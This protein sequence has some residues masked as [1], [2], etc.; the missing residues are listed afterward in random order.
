MAV[1]ILINNG[2][3]LNASFQGLQMPP[4]A[5]S[6]G[7]M[8]DVVTL[9]NESWLGAAAP[10]LHLPALAAVADRFDSAD[11]LRFPNIISPE[12]SVNRR[13]GIDYY[14]EILEQIV[15]VSTVLKEKQ[16][17]R[18][19]NLGCDCGTDFA[20]I[21]YLL[22]R[23]REN[24][25][26]FWFDAHADLNTP[27]TSTGGSPS[28]HFHGMVL[29]ALTGHTAFGLSN[30]LNPLLLPSRII[31]AG[32]REIDP[33][34]RDYIASESIIIVSPEDIGQSSWLAALDA[35]AAKGITNAYIHIDFDVLDPEKFP[36]VGCPTPGGVSIE[37]LRLAI[38]QIYDRFD[39]HGVSAV[40][41]SVEGENAIRAAEI[42]EELIA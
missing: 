20:P 29:R 1:T 23:Y 15:R 25:L 19:R 28:G 12:R 42:V 30:H 11:V 37:T 9:I 32:V 5:G 6:G 3:R 21:A 36:W 41:I 39:V 38:A 4:Y 10:N 22:S 27:A 35:S 26:V 24:L 40:E 33:E 16:P 7:S 31:L 8:Q 18:I 17:A 13:N 14:D 34:E 2:L